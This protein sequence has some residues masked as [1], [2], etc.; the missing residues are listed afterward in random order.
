MDTSEA[1]DRH[2][3][4]PPPPA[5]RSERA[6][7]QGR[8]VGPMLLLLALLVAGGGF[9]LFYVL[10]HAPAVEAL[11]ATSSELREERG[12]REA[13]EARVAELVAE[14]DRLQR[15]VGEL[16]AG[17]QALRTERDQL[18]RE[19]DVLRA[20]NE[21]AQAALAA[22]RE[23]QDALRARL[24]AEL[25]SGEAQ[26]RGDSEEVAIALDERI[27]FPPGASE[28]NERGLEVLARVAQSLASLPDRVVR[29]EGHTDSTP[30]TGAN[31]E[32]FP[33]NWELSTARATS[34][35]RFLEQQ[36]IAGERLAAVGYG[37][38]HPVADNRT[39]I[40]R[41]RNRRIEI[42]VARHTVTEAARGE[43]S[44][45]GGDRAAR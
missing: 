13:L 39:A 17:E 34:V 1:A 14:R 21:Q 7:A 26:M 28:L 15:R 44:G 36:G 18:T 24:S 35:V 9:L 43:L 42:V 6:P 30:L 31:A 12:Q 25:D 4:P 16:R 32:R 41:R 29:I 10:E 27:L 33:T 19:R 45:S 38:H 40:G 37:A 5:A 3:P 23:A 2:V 20:G 22:M 8:S 11:R